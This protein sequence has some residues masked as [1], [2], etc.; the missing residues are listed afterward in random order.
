[1]DNLAKVKGLPAN[2]P[3]G[4]TPPIIYDLST[5][6]MEFQQN[7]ILKAKAGTGLDVRLGGANGAGAV[8]QLTSP[9]T[10]V[11]LNRRS[12]VITTV[13]GTL[14]AGGEEAFT[15]TNSEIAV[16]DVVV[17]CMGDHASAG[18]PVAVVLSVAAGSCVIAV[19]NLH[20]ANA[21]NAALKINF[22]VLKP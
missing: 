17:V 8:T 4:G 18:T 3:V 14:A 15:L 7:T 12:G 5:H 13:A 10:G 21:L 22:M 9:T 19:T 20:A 1:M 2:Q 6:T 11:T 16:G